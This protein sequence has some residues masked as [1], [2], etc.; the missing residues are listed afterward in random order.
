MEGGVLLAAAVRIVGGV[1]AV[2][3][4]LETAGLT[5][6]SP[7]PLR[8]TRLADTDITRDTAAAEATPAYHK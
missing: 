1:L 6:P 5:P 3:I 4:L 2:A 8:E 7:L